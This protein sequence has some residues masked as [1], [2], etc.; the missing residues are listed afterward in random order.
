MCGIAGAFVLGAQDVQILGNKLTQNLHHRGPDDS[1]FWTDDKMYLG[2]TRLSIIGLENG[3]Q[4]FI[5][6]EGNLICVVNGEIYNYD[7]LAKKFDLNLNSSSD[8]AVIIPLYQKLGLSFIDQLTGMFS[9]AL[10]DRKKN[11]LFLFRD[12]A[13]EKPLYFA[14]GQDKLIFASEMQAVSKTQSSLHIDHDSVAE[15]F[16]FQYVPEPATLFKEIRKLK[17]GHL[18]T[19]DIAKHSYLERRYWSP[20]EAPPVENKTNLS[21]TEVIREAFVQAVDYCSI[22]D[23][24]VAVSLS[25]GIDS[26]A[27]LACMAKNQAIVSPLAITLGYE[28][29]VPTDER[30]K[31]AS[32]CDELNVEHHTYVTS[33]EELTTL[34]PEVCIARDDPIGDISGINYY[35]IARECNR[36]G[37]KVLLQGHGADEIFWGYDWVRHAVVRE[38]DEDRNGSVISKI[39][40]R[41]LGKKN[42]SFFE[43]QPFVR[44]ILDNPYFLNGL[45][46]QRLN[47]LTEINYAKTNHRLDLFLT[48][49]MFSTY[50]RENGL[51]QTDRLG[52]YFSVESRQPFVNHK[53]VEKVID[54][55]RQNPDHTY[56]GKALLKEA[57]EGI[58]PEA[59]LQRKKQGF[60]PP[61]GEMQDIIFRKYRTEVLDGFLLNSGLISKGHVKKLLDK[62]S[63]SGVESTFLR[64]LFTLEMWISPFKSKVVS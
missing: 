35:L 20:L 59:V 3:R 17:A 55:R 25:G 48:N 54:L 1:N 49:L 40:G 27:I 26:S 10:L 56:T 50:L 29:S 33:L 52:M 57:L 45:T 21:A 42:L 30:F 58:I 2:H 7:E 5:G 61:V 13:G 6:D 4:P 63:R 41:F 64:L 22:S 8:C 37:V 24:P 15:F 43:E 46:L 44:Y 60:T 47:S 19:Y 16:R 31:A 32:L 28:G 51:S 12:R 11:K 23:A 62:R 53:F 38:M 36:L 18:I 9:I 39:K 34:F 14:F